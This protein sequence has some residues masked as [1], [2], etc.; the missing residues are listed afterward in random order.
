MAAP[1]I[2]V[3][4][5]LDALRG[6]DGAAG[7]RLLGAV[8][9]ELHRLARA[10]RRHERPDHTLNTTA[11]VHEAY[12]KLLGPDHR[13]YESRA[14]FFASATRAMRQ[15]L[16][17]YARAR[18]RTK[19]GSGQ[20]AVSLDA[21]Q[22]SAEPADPGLLSDAAAAEVLDVDAALHRL[23]LLDERQVRVVECRYF[24][25]LSVEETAEALGLSPATV[26]REWRS[27]RAWLYAA[28]HD[29][30]GPPPALGPPD[31]P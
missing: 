3:T 2:D 31:A 10:Q 21:L 29:G 19:R 18:G 5:A 14:H 27:A 26:K 6:G 1:S 28:L 8:Y 13:D 12:L 4:E 20:A 23:A 9:D 7:D 25:G 22:G 15:V 16:V 11:L 17:D 24:G 30:E